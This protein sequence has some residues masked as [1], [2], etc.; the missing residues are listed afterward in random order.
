MNTLAHAHALLKE[1]PDM[2]PY[3]HFSI[4]RGKKQKKEELMGEYE[5]MRRELESLAQHEYKRKGSM[6]SGKLL[7]KSKELDEI[8]NQIMDT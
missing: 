7:D 5:N 2:D 6:A 3:R 1:G 8:G 4:A